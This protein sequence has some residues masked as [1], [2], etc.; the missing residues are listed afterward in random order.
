MHIVV[1]VWEQKYKFSYTL[2][3]L[4]NH[5]RLGLNKLFIKV[6]N[7]GQWETVRQLSIVDSFT[8]LV[9]MFL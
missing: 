1:D 5:G 3:L 6:L 8:Y 7:L 4:H 2:H 9:K